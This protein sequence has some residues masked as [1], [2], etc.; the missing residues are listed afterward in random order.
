VIY[1][2]LRELGRRTRAVGTAVMG[3]QIMAGPIRTS[4]DLA[5]YLWGGR[6]SIAGVVVT[7]E[8]AWK[9]SVVNACTR[10]LAESVAS[11]PL[12]VFKV[13]EG[14]GSKRDRGSN[15]DRILSIK[16]NKWQTSSEWRGMMMVH[17]V[18][19]GN[20]FSLKIKIADEVVELI[21]LHPD[22]MKWGLSGG[23]MWYEYTRPDGTT[24]PYSQADIFH[25][26]GLS[27]DGVSGRDMIADMRESI[28]IA[29]QQENW[30]GASYAR[31]GTKRP[32]LNHPQ[33]LNEQAARRI[34]DSWMENYGGE[35][36]MWK[37]VVLEEGMKLENMDLS[38]SDM[39]FLESRRFRLADLAR[40]FRVPLHMLADLG[41]AAD[42]KNEAATLDFV[43]FTLT[44][45]F[46]RWEERI[47][48]DLLD[49][50]GSRFAKHNVKGMLRGDSQKRGEYFA[51]ALQFGWMCIDEVRALDDMNPL[52][53][54]LGKKF[55]I[56]VNMQE[57]GAA[58]AALPAP[59]QPSRSG[60]PK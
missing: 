59:A 17:A 53:N 7:D 56:Q 44:P 35:K 34:R 13:L 60:E 41:G 3:G 50:D 15:I 51:K 30:E 52:P 39:Q 46:V 38:A 57:V 29:T 47:Q 54:G 36:G 58:P 28:G 48:V 22:R 5:A 4:S 23:E 1:P 24:V 33:L 11:L 55:Y 2:I 10:I 37:P 6:S 25:L 8:T 20:A 45:W 42:N 12:G 43:V 31:G 49:D 9:V 14:G 16:P 26:R 19:R 27:S 32:V 21:P 18:R 40:P